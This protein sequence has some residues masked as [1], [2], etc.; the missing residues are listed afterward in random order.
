M[1]KAISHAR[2]LMRNEVVMHVETVVLIHRKD[3]GMAPITD[4]HSYKRRT[5]Q[6]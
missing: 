2:M 1:Q 5:W 4:M 3:M 6:D